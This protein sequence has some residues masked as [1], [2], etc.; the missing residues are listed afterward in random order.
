MKNQLHWEKKNVM[1][2]S[3][4]EKKLSVVIKKARMKNH[5]L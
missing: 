1:K 2:V 5:L 4:N 3:C